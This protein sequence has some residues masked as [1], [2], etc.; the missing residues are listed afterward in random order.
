MLL[1]FHCMIQS[2]G[3]SLYEEPQPTHQNVKK[4]QRLWKP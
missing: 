2:L 4:S 3:L 1:R